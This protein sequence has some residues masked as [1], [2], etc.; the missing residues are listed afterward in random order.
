MNKEVTL[1]DV[2]SFT[3]EQFERIKK[4]NEI[5]KLVHFHTINK[6]L[7]MA[8]NQSG[9]KTL[10]KL[11]ANKDKKPINIIFQEYEYTLNQ[12]L[13][14]EATIPSISNVLNKIYSHFK[15]KFTLEEKK[16]FLRTIEDY[17][18]QKISLGEILNHVDNYIH[19]YENGYLQR[20]T[21]YLLYSDIEYDNFS[22]N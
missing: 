19:K 21:F 12:I 2:R 15:K 13:I 11:V 10:G 9:L 20:Q 8:Q 6:Y 1:E 17:R 14:C 18:E 22:L 16:L 3:K 4:S 5:K 7:F